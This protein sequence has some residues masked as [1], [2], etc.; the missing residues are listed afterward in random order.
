MSEAKSLGKEVFQILEQTLGEERYGDLEKMRRLYEAWEI[1]VGEETSRRTGPL[2]LR[3]GRLV[4][5]AVSSAWCNEM[6][7][8]RDELKKNAREKLGI[9]LKEVVV[10]IKT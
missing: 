1:L 3:D 10:R 4:V 9:D 7:M 2:L 6:S 8:R 5:G